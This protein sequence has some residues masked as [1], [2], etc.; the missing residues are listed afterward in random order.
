MNNSQRTV[1][2]CI[3]AGNLLILSCGPG[4]LFG[5]TPTPTPTA[6]PPATPTPLATPTSPA[7]APGL[8]KGTTNDNHPVS[9]EVSASG[10]QVVKF[11]IENI[12]FFTKDCGG[13]TSGTFSQTTEGLL[14]IAN[15]QFNFSN[16][17]Y[18]F[19][20]QFISTTT[21]TGTYEF[22]RVTIKIASPPF[23]L[24]EDC[25]FDFILS[26]TWTAEAP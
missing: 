26:G 12:E 8:W 25:A 14:N 15:D 17:N 2:I 9:F 21:A 18:S 4:L 24:L 11:L 13:E 23:Y 1:I 20:G 7:P 6:T 16:E 5:P 19:K 3:L 10:D 22:A